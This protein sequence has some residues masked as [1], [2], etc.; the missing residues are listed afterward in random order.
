MLTPFIEQDGETVAAKFSLEIL[1]ELT[2]AL[3]I[4]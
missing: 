1:G 4:K 2:G 3:N